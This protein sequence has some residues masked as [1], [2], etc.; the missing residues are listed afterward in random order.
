MKYSISDCVTR[1]NQA[2]NYPSLNFEDVYHFFD[3]AISE[4]NTSLRISLPTV[5]EMR[6]EHTINVLDNPNVVYIE[7][8]P[9]AAPDIPTRA[10]DSPVEGS[11]RY[12]PATRSF[13]IFQNGAWATY[14]RLY[15][16]HGIS[17]E[18]YISTRFTSV[19]IWSPLDKTVTQ[20][21][22]LTEYLPVDWI[23]LFIIPY[24]CYKFSTRS[25]DTGDIYRDEFVQ[26][27]QQL[28]TSYSVPNNTV[29]SK[30]AGQPAYTNIVK[31]NLNN[32]NIKV[33]TRAIYEWMKNLN[34]MPLQES[35][36]FDT[37]GWGV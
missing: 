23:N 10:I 16:I 17:Q 35:H 12:D 8:N 32:L 36:I 24:V 18:T 26:G 9:I 30:V 31:E 34:G 1:I 4:L 6:E 28:Q 5:T 29:L 3:Q 13:K 33:P 15:G 22:D 14:D 21:F 2:L 37:G 27:F 25:G 19:A 11:F 20:E 7:S